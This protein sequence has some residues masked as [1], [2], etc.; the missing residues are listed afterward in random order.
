MHCVVVYVIVFMYGCGYIIVH[1]FTHSL[2]LSF[3]LSWLHNK[4][5]AGR[6][7]WWYSCCCC[8]FFLHGNLFTARESCREVSTFRIMHCRIEYRINFYIRLCAMQCD[9]EM[10]FT[11][12]EHNELKVLNEKW[13]W[14]G[15]KAILYIYKSVFDTDHLVISAVLDRIFLR[16]MF[17]IFVAIAAKKSQK[18]NR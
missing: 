9:F 3:S 6:F 16:W 12:T 15:K 1:L 2:T 13:L 18:I 7:S 11:H 17:N 8:S 4:R 5:N 10:Q 14:C